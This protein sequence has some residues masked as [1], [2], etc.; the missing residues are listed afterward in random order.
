M[1]PLSATYRLQLRQGVDFDRAR[2]LL[3][4]IADL[5]ARQ[6]YL[7]PIFTA[8]SDSTHGYD[9][10]DPS[11]IDPVLGGREGFERLA[12]DAQALGLGIVLDL[13]P[14]HT[15]LSVENPWLFDAL[16]YGA[17][18]R[19]ADYFDI[20]W[21]YGLILPI[22]P[23]RYDTMLA[24]GAFHVNRADERLEW[25]GGW[26]PLAPGTAEIDDWDTMMAGQHWQLRFWERERRRLTH[27]RFFNVT[28]LIG[29]QIERPEVFEAMMA[30]PVALV[31]EGLVQ[32]LRIDHV[33]GLAW[34]GEYMRRLRE[35]VGPDCP[36]WVEKILTGDE[37]MPTSWPIEGTTGYEVSDRISR[38]LTDPEGRDALDRF[39][40]EATGITGDYEDMCLETRA[41]ILDTDLRAELV[42]M[43][44][45]A[46]KALAEREARPRDA[47][48]LSAAIRA[49]LMV[50]P[51][52][53]SYVTPDG[54]RAEDEALLRHSFERAAKLLDDTGTLDAL[55]TLFDGP[56]GPETY[57]FVRRFQQVTGAVVAKAQEDTAFFRYTRNLAEC[58]VGSEPDASPLSAEAF[59]AWCSDRQARWPKALS[60]SS[61][62]DSKRAEDA[63][64]RL[65]ALTHDS[66]ALRQLWQAAAPHATTGAPQAHVRWY[67]LQ[68]AVAMWQPERDDLDARLAAHL[69]KALREARQL[70]TWTEPDEAAERQAA[71]FGQA[72]LADWR[73][74]VPPALARIVA[75]GERLSLV[76]QALKCLVP[77]VPDVYQGTEIGSFALT[78]PDNRDPLDPEPPT[79][80]FGRDKLALTRRLLALRAADPEFFLTADCTV[81]EEGGVI[82]LSR[83]IGDRRVDLRFM[84]DGA[85]VAGKGPVVLD[86]EGIEAAEAVPG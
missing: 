20:D 59:A 60:L 18:S 41:L 69:E 58:E 75:A 10:A 63:R 81:R 37:E 21:S 55:R 44:T 15:V 3:P 70:S 82:H 34:P 48:D 79:T 17:E 43:T 22:L 86:V 65:I 64:A 27:R 5:G 40:R 74:E 35:E 38:L 84:R 71:A 32:G 9:V 4:Y 28:T 66:E 39:W 67:V 24:D 53:R 49:L 2:A 12:R 31:R 14:N 73:R 47:A 8:E 51:Q 29:M 45:R 72:L 7:S 13:V 26:L 23:E 54:A 16:K 33:D 52:Y 46:E 57:G 11:E 1:T 6:L 68:T 36:V 50:F 56:E 30:L 85:P 42:E 61:S 78:D 77:G 19:Y 25:E 62:H 80:S 76:Q 83:R